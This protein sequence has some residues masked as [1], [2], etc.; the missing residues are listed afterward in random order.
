MTAVNL[1]LLFSVDY[2]TENQLP[3]RCIFVRVLVLHQENLMEILADF[4]LIINKLALS[5]S[6]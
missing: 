5:S 4:V 6:C 2:L 1:S 3:L